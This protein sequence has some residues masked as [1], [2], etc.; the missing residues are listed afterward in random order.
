MEI[1]YMDY[2]QNPY[3]IFIL[4]NPRNI[5]K[6]YF[7]AFYLD[8]YNWKNESIVKLALIILNKSFQ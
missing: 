2:P 5:K 7:L 6:I 4:K 3:P 8:Q 1:E